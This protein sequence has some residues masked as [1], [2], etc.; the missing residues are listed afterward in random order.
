MSEFDILSRI[1]L[2]VSEELTAFELPV[3]GELPRELCGLYVRNGP[4][5]R[6][7]SGHPFFGDGMLHGVWI[8]DGRARKYAN[9]W[10]RTLQ[11]LQR[12][13]LR[14]SVANT[15]VIAHGNRILALEETAFPYQVDGDLNTVG[16]FDFGGRLTTPMTAHPKRCPASGDLLFFGASWNPAE[17]A[18][19]YH[20]ANSAGELMESR[21]IAVPGHTMMHDFAITE[22]YVVFMDLPVVFDALRAKEGTMPFRWSDTYGA[23]FGIMERASLDIRWFGVDPCYVFHV[24]NAHEDGSSV[25]VDGV[26]YPELWRTSPEDFGKP[27]LHQWTFDLDAGT[28]RERALDDFPVEFPRINEART[29]RAYRYGYAVHNA[30]EGGGTFVKYDLRTGVSLRREL[31]LAK[32]PA[33]PVFIAAQDA[34]SEDAGWLVSY[35]YDAARDASDL[36]VMDAR[37]MQTVATVEL[38]QRVPFGFHGA[39]IDAHR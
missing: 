12:D 37:D 4:N 8:E 27:S 10:V 32:V 35:V 11:S 20:R 31:P 7:P 19:T 33:E 36:L 26:R 16:P 1:Y 18:L 39:W 29:G 6:S 24:L 5:P 14:R 23:R 3:R 30:P 28:A 9:R 13:D 22:N 15:N 34:R 21:E 2:P 25:V 38:P 17:P